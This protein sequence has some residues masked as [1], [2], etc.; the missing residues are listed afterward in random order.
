VRVAEIL[1][2]DVC[3]DDEGGR[4][5]ECWRT[6]LTAN[7]LICAFDLVAAMPRCRFRLR[8][9][10]IICTGLALVVGGARWW[11]DV[12]MAS[13]DR[14]KA[15]V[16]ELHALEAISLWSYVGPTRWD[17]G[18]TLDGPLF[19]RPTHLYC[20]DVAPEAFPGVVQRLAELEVKTLAVL[21][22]HIMP[23]AR[24][25]EAGKPD[26]VIEALRQHP[27]LQTI[28]VDSSIRGTPAEFDQPIYTREDLAL[29]EVLLPNVEIEWIE[30]N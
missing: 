14:Q 26:E 12:R 10:L 3:C 27:T 5:C 13:F 25:V 24:A 9:L 18:K 6:E 1:G 11:Y 7:Y 29:L 21:A 16:K 22:L 2:G 8:T 17:L 23:H 15:V 30:V 19:R 28:V 4:F 20:D